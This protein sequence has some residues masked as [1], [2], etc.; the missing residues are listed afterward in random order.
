MKKMI[1]FAAIM[2][3]QLVSAQERTQNIGDFTAVR[4][5]DQIDVLL[6]KSSENKIVIKGSRKDD[7]EVVT[8]NNEL[9]IRMKFSKLLKGDDIS[10][11]VYYNT[12]I[13]Q[14]DASEG[15]R[16][17][18]QDIFKATAF[19]ISAKEGAEV[20]LKLDVKKLTSKAY[21]GGILDITGTSDNHDIVINTGGIFKGRQFITK[22]TSVSVNAGGEA[23]VNATEF[24][25]AR[26]KAGG[27][28]N[29]YGNPPQVNKKTFA[30]GDIN[31]KS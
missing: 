14:V 28:I 25:D 24:V 8:K 11:T 30:G 3:F 23:D 29:V 7:V 4:A 22:Q 5:F 20:K 16:V 12:N 21:S 18:S 2:L 19:A 13:D 10:V 26:T 6:V 31:I 1:V 9:K 17:A 15:A 27:N